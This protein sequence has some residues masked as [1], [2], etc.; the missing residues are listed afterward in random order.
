MRSLWRAKNRQHIGSD[1]QLRVPFDT[2]LTYSV[3]WCGVGAIKLAFG[4]Y[5]LILPLRKPLEGLLVHPFAS[6]EVKHCELNFQLHNG[7][8]TREAF[9]ELLSSH[10]GAE[11]KERCFCE[12]D[13]WC[14]SLTRT[15]TRTRT[16][17]L[18]LALALALARTLTRCA[19]RH[20]AYERL[21]R[22]LMV[23]LRCTV[24]WLV[25]QFDTYIW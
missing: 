24:P 25:F 3:F 4:Y 8:I 15:R 22:L 21:M 11:W 17:T 2:W 12:A 7:P 20:N 9:G 1:A 18:A 23:L 14:A 13:G 19:N 16:L 6:I 10:A 5:S